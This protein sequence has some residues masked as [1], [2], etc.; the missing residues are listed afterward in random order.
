M[1]QTIL[2]APQ[3]AVNV[4]LN[5]TGDP[6]KGSGARV[7]GLETLPVIQYKVQESQ[8]VSGKPPNPTGDPVK[9]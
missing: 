1:D 4:A 5:P 2:G 6:V 9:G 8:N 3:D 7:W